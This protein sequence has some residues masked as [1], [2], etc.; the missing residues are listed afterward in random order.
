MLRAR[1]YDKNRQNTEFVQN[2]VHKG[3]TLSGMVWLYFSPKQG[4]RAHQLVLLPLDVAT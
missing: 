3:N 1:L 2:S 4:G